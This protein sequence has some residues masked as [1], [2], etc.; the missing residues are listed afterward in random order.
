MSYR[1]D[2]ASTAIA[3]NALASSDHAVTAANLEA[4]LLGQSASLDLAQALLDHARSGYGV[5]TR[6]RIAETAR[7]PVESLAVIV[8]GHPR[9]LTRAPTETLADAARADDDTTRRWAD[10]A[11]YALTARR[12]W[13]ASLPDSRPTGEAGWS[14]AADAARLAHA[15][16]GHTAS[17]ADQL[18][19]AGRYVEADAFRQA[20]ASGLPLAASEVVDTAHAGPIAPVDDPRPPA[21]VG[22]IRNTN[23]LVDAQRRLPRLL[24]QAPTMSPRSV[25]IVALGQIRL[26]GILAA[27]ASDTD[28]VD[29]PSRLHTLASA[30]HAARLS[31][32]Q[33]ET[34]HR[35]DK[36][37]EHQ[38]LELLTAAR[39][40]LDPASTQRIAHAL[41]QTAP[42]IFDTLH[43]VAQREHAN[44]RWYIPAPVEEHLPWK[45]GRSGIEDELASLAETA[46]Q[47]AVD[48]TES[49][50]THTPAPHDI[51]S[52]LATNRARPPD[53][54]QQTV[55]T[56]RPRHTSDHQHQPT[57]ATGSY[58]RPAG[59][60]ARTGHLT[61]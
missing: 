28:A 53:P 15:A 57:T 13:D 25:K 1:H 44:L 3:L 42:E 32:L 10:V 18:D 26:A 20:D 35:T 47:I 39:R 30:S 37:P 22:I 56:P 19:A 48:A 6:P 59:Q 4:A 23:Q 9:S 33:V 31:H 52:H 61:L 60:D 58:G 50:P 34:F 16:F 7:D 54:R 5:Q 12:D 8:R 11:R 46:H 24:R 51:L 49:K 40:Q 17:I 27:E 29:Y 55:R 36:R 45:I 38:S 21:R 41:L 43:A 14:L 2:A